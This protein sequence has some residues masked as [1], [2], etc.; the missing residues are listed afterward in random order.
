MSDD[1]WENFIASIDPVAL[2]AERMR[3]HGNLMTERFGSRQHHETVRAHEWLKAHRQDA[4]TAV[5]GNTPCEIYPTVSDDELLASLEEVAEWNARQTVS[6]HARDAANQKY[7]QYR[8]AARAA[9]KA[10]A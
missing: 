8:D 6:R 1:A 10:A 7:K 9:R 2:E 3:V 4:T 5:T